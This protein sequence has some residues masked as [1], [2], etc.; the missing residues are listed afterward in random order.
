MQTIG[1]EVERYEQVVSTND[2]VRERAE[3]GAAEGLVIV[4]EEQTAGRGRMGR[5]WL[6][7]KGSSLQFSILLEPPLAPWEAFRLTQIAALA[8]SSTLRREFGLSPALK[9][10]N[11]V[12]LNEKKCAGILIETALEGDALAFAI[13]GIGLNV[14]YSMCD[15]PDLAAFAT[16]IQDEL[17]HPADR[18]ELEAALLSKLDEYYGRLRA[19][20]DFYTEWREQ[21]STLG[22]PI[23][24]STPQ[25]ILTGIAEDVA[26]DGA[27][28]LRCNGR[29]IPLYAGDVT[30][31]R[32]AV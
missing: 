17:G 9:W 28:L 23:R 2:R 27:L 3:Q 19:G 13:L 7:P 20:E 14:N 26:R 15:Y 31:L 24:V 11:D 10:P 22:R 29:L 4:A 5:R 1:R 30:V 21:V 32:D 12:L 6:A 25:G 8:I 16:T 18:D